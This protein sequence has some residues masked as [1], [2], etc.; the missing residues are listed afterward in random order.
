MN[1]L[2]AESNSFGMDVFDGEMEKVIRA[3][4]TE[5]GEREKH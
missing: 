4:K 3:L 2:L 5:D 1:F